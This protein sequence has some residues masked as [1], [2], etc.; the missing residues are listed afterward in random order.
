[1]TRREVEGSRLQELFVMLAT[2]ESVAIP[3]CILKSPLNWQS[4]LSNET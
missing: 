1:M 3:V 4:D 2:Q